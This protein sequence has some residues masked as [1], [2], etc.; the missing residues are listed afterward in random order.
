MLISHNALSI[1]Q[2]MVQEDGAQPGRGLSILKAIIYF[3][4]APVGLFLL[5]TAGVLLST[6][7]KKKI[8]VVV[9]RID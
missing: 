5:I 9:D 8:S 2:R 1:A 3:G 4:V 6:V 7:K